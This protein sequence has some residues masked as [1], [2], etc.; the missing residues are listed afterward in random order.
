MQDLQKASP[1]TVIPQLQAQLFF[2]S[3]GEALKSLPPYVADML[4][5]PIDTKLQPPCNCVHVLQD[6]KW[7]DVMA[8]T[9][10]LLLQGYQ[11]GSQPCAE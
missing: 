10:I 2:P 6:G 11:D 1:A 4:P 7:I 5:Y 3:L 8:A 9:Q